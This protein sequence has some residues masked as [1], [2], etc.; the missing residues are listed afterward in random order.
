MWTLKKLIAVMSSWKRN[1]GRASITKGDL[2]VVFGW[3]YEHVDEHL[4][5]DALGYYLLETECTSVKEFVN[6]T[7]FEDER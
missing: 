7:L 5:A 1:E 2:A 6:K 3:N 4:L